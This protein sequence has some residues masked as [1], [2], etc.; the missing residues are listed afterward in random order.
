[1][2]ESTLQPHDP[3]IARTPGGRHVLT[4]LAADPVE[5]LATFYEAVFGWARRVDVGH[6]VELDLPGGQG[7]GIYRRDILERLT[8][9]SLPAVEAGE[10][11]GVELYFHCADLDAAI[12]RLAEV[13][14]T[15]LNPRAPRDWGDEAA[16]YADPEGN[17]LVVARPLA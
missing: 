5:R 2:P 1:M 7:L 14:A 13:G 16:Y 15:I 3:A 12:E 17:I 11:R 8:G 6:Y 10:A 9:R 4:I